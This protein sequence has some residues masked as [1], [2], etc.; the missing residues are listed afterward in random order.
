LQ[1]Q[2]VSVA[3]GKLVNAQATA[4]L[5]A[6]ISR[7]DIPLSQI[8]TSNADSPLL[9]LEILNSGMDSISIVSMECGAPIPRNLWA[10]DE[11]AVYLHPSDS[12]RFNFDFD[13]KECT[14]IKRVVVRG[15]SSLGNPVLGS[16][17]LQIISSAIEDNQSTQS[18][19][20]LVGT[21]LPMGQAV[22]NIQEGGHY[23]LSFEVVNTHYQDVQIDSLK[24]N[25][26]EIPGWNGMTLLAQ[27]STKSTITTSYGI[28]SSDIGTS[29][30]II[31]LGHIFGSSQQGN[32][33]SFYATTSALVYGP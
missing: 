14:S 17:E 10:T 13:S 1:V 24:V 6:P 32:D 11:G 15:E 3:S 25:G 28:N 27:T 18:P 26:A 16:A 23:V 12:K 19:T 33:G 20:E 29:V 7:M 30:D 21:K 8:D 5:K 4:I 2:G 31:I 22:I 9:V